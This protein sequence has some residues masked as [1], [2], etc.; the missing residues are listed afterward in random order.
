MT[1]SKGLTHW[2]SETV[3]EYSEIEG[4]P[5]GSPPQPTLSVVKLEG[6]PAGSVKPGQKSC[7]RS[8]EIITL[9]AQQLSGGSGQSPPQ[10]RP[11]LSITSGSPM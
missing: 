1:G 8:S 2:I 3:Y 7:V 11:Q 10:R 4:S 5:Q 6:G 9:S